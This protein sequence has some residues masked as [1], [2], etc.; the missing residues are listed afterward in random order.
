M[1]IANKEFSNF[2]M[3]VQKESAVQVLSNVWEYRLPTWV[4]HVVNVFERSGNATAETTMSPYLWTGSSNVSLGLVIPKYRANE[5]MKWSWEGN[6]TIRLH[7]FTEAKE[8]I[9]EVA[10]R[11]AKMLKLTI[12]SDASTNTKMFLPNTPTL[13]EYETEEGVFINTDFQ[14]TSTYNVLGTHIGNVRRC[15]YSTPYVL[16]G[17]GRKHELTFDQNFDSLLVAGDTVE[18]ILA[19]PDEH[20]R[21]LI[22]KVAQACFQQKPNANAL[23]TIAYELGEEL[24]KFMNY[25]SSPRDRR[26]ETY[27]KR[28]TQ[29]RRTT[30]PERPFYYGY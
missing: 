17:G 5:G 10:A 28:G 18:S 11:P 1:C 8:L 30:D 14:V 29:A 21:V 16:S 27:I 15:V 25:A 12:D 7:K 13:G 2:S 19:I 4:M 26:G 24:Q 3:C 23:S 22:L 9:V 20:T 6:H